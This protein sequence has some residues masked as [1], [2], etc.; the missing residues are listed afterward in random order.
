M[1][2]PIFPFIYHSG[3]AHMSIGKAPGK[4]IGIFRNGNKVGMISHQAV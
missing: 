2:L 3:I 1:P 4:R